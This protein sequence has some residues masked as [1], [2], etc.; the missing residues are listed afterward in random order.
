MYSRYLNDIINN[1]YYAYDIFYLAFNQRLS[2]KMA[3]QV[4]NESIQEK[5]SMMFGENGFCT[6][7]ILRTDFKNLGVIEFTNHEVYPMFGFRPD[8]LVGKDIS[9]IM[10]ELIG[11]VHRQLMVKFFDK[12]ESPIINKFRDLF[13]KDADGYLVPV[14][15]Y[16][17]VLPNLSGGLKFIGAIKRIIHLDYPP[18]VT[19]DLAKLG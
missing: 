14:I 5:E 18:E 11:S 7:F 17:K 3:S 13:V 6:I 2:F 8:W 9:V 19:G 4:K 10:P 1:E 12:G 15:I 16:P